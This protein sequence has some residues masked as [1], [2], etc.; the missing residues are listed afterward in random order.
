VLAEKL[1]VE[2]DVALKNKL[3][4]VVISRGDFLKLTGL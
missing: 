3:E 2:L 1:G 4:S